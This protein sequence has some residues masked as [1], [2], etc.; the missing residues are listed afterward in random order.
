MYFAWTTQ[1]AY[2]SLNKKKRKFNVRMSNEREKK[3]I[4]HELLLRSYDNKETDSVQ[5]ITL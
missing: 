5:S 2:N 4:M 3:H 1:Y